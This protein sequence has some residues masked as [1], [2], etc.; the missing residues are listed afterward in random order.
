[1]SDSAGTLLYPVGRV[2]DGES[3]LAMASDGHVY[4]GNEHAELLSRH[5]YEALEVLGVERRT[6]ARLPFVPDRWS[7]ETE[8]VLRLAGW[9]PGRAVSATSG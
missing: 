2:D 1:M 5:G 7:P 4:V 3:F 8:R 6:D 9:W